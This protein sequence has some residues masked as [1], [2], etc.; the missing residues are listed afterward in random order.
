LRLKF[1]SA[2]TRRWKRPWSPKESS[3]G[4]R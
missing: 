4:G 1:F 3:S 2:V